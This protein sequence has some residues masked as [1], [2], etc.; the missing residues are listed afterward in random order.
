MIEN[1]TI[2]V[3]FEQTPVSEEE[4]FLNFELPETVKIEDI[5]IEG[6]NMYMGKTPVLFEDENAPNRGVTFLGSCNLDEMQWQLKVQLSVNSKQGQHTLA[7][8]FNTYLN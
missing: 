3:S 2:T 6:V 8:P 7:L 4:L 5:W 1:H